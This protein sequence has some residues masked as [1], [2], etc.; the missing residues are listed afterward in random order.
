MNQK[1]KLNLDD[2]IEK[3]SHNFFEV[4]GENVVD[5]D[6]PG[7][8]K[9]LREKK[10]LMMKDVEK[11]P[12]SE[13]LTEFTDDFINSALFT[14]NFNLIMFRMADLNQKKEILLKSNF[15]MDKH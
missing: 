11:M 10:A 3:M 1:A 13:L 9:M 5:L 12:V 4:V 7:L 14:I 8:A 6:Q 2:Y 15:K